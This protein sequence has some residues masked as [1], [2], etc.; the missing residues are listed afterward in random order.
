MFLI[1]VVVVRRVVGMGGILE[2]LLFVGTL[3]LMVD[4][5]LGRHLVRG[6]RDRGLYRRGDGIGLC[7]V[8]GHFARNRRAAVLVMV[9]FVM[10][11]VMPMVIMFVMIVMVLVVMRLVLV[12]AMLGM[13]MMQVVMMAGVG[14]MFLALV[15]LR[16][17]RRI[18]VRTPDHVALDPLAMAAAA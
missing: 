18:E 15:G 6:R 13:V 7:I 17:L 9:V 4:V 12:M 2:R 3:G 16:R 10:I 14:V 11:V 8:R 5:D 1:V